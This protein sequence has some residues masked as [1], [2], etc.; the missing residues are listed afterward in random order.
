MK[1][2]T[3]N[4]SNSDLVIIISDESEDQAR[5]AI[6]EIC[7][8]PGF[9]EQLVLDD[10]DDEED[11]SEPT[12]EDLQY[13]QDR[14]AEDKE[15]VIIDCKIGP[16]PK[17]FADPMPVVNVTFDNHTTK[18]LFSFYPDELRFDE[19]EFIGLTEME[20]RKLRTDRDIAYLQS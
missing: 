3:F 17:S 9:V 5:D 7:S 16:Y 4:D 14:I 20:A 2:Y 10:E 8:R 12:K 1:T 13:A 18:D 11:C 19:K 6:Q 15:P